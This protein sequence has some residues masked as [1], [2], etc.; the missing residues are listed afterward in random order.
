MKRRFTATAAALLIILTRC[1]SLSADDLSGAGHEYDNI[2]VAEAVESA[3]G[4]QAPA[5]S[6]AREGSLKLYAGFL[7]TLGVMRGFDDGTFRP[8]AP[9]LKGDACVITAAAAG[10]DTAAFADAPIG[11]FYDVDR[12]SPYFSAVQALAAYGILKGN[13]D[14]T[15]NVNTRLTYTEAVV[16]LTRVMG[17]EEFARVS[18]GYP[19][20]YFAAA[21]RAGVSFRSADGMTRGVFAEFIYNM[22]RSHPLQ[23]NRAGERNTY[24][25]NTEETFLSERHEVYEGD[26]IVTATRAGGLSGGAV[27]RGTV[28][29]DEDV[30]ALDQKA[31]AARLGYRTQFFYRDDDGAYTVIY[32][33][34]HRKVAEIEIDAEDY[35]NYTPSA[36][37][38]RYTEDD[39]R[40]VLT[41]VLSDAPTVLINGTA[42]AVPSLGAALEIQQGSITLVS[43]YDDDIY[44]LVCVN[45]YENL[46]LQRASADGGHTITLTPQYSLLPITARMSGDT[47]L[48]FANA[49]G[50]EVEYYADVP[51]VFGKDGKPAKTIDVSRIPADCVLSAFADKYEEQRGHLLPAGDA[52]YTRFVI[53]TRKIEGTI[54]AI[55]G[56]GNV[57]IGGKTFKSSPSNY[58]NELDGALTLGKTGLFYLDFSGEIVAFKESGA[59]DALRYGYLIN[60]GS[61]RGALS[62]TLQLKIMTDDGEI[63]VVTTERKTNVNGDSLS[64]DEALTLLKRVAGMLRGGFGI[65][66]MIR[67]RLTAD[68]ML[69]ELET[70]LPEDLIN[71]NGLVESAHLQRSVPID[72][73]NLVEDTSGRL[74]RAADDT[75]Y[76]KPNKYFF[77]PSP[78][79]FH[80]E[81]YSVQA[82]ANARPYSIELYDCGF[83]MRPQIA[84]IYA[85]AGGAEQEIITTR[86]AFPVMVS[87]V[88]K[89][90][91]KDGAAVGAVEVATGVVM[92]EY[93]GRDEHTFDGL[94]AGDLIQLYTRGND[95][96]SSYRR[97][98]YY[99][100]PITAKTFPDLDFDALTDGGSIR[101]L[102]AGVVYYV[103]SQSGLVIDTGRYGADG[104]RKIHVTG[105][106]N[107]NYYW[108]MGGAIVYDATV[109]AKPQ[110]RN[111]TISDFKGMYQYGEQH[112]S[113][114]LWI[115]A[116]GGGRQY[117][118]Y[119]F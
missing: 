82:P 26:G 81:D 5:F 80:D 102:Y 98:T 9:V 41:A 101:S 55:D 117:I 58:F 64:K 1:V 6:D 7:D 71:Q 66:Q 84:L 68:G 96:V 42:A 100:I 52:V 11:T 97:H 3:P 37:T 56:E 90:L 75:G 8:D 19:E 21:R 114:V 23:K 27:K 119:N 78:E 24:A 108:Q 91:D 36:K 112:A 18:G 109:G 4:E 12:D 105:H 46:L 72:E 47:I 62:D 99:N 34:D 16:L 49:D 43:N 13:A 73:Y 14:N 104:R 10:I 93:I 25:V 111:A 63:I 115:P 61:A 32:L 57:E 38:I 85:D 77:V 45:R 67:Y 29:I 69:A 54:E 79:T 20:G 28:K 83:D 74:L 22:L 35:V 107:T 33:I 30:Y 76:H 60:A 59:T 70:C 95:V 94:E 31:G 106:M 15:V 92:K 44:D 113:R 39:G 110:V 116:H 40:R 48:E 50:T 88:F 2:D 87:R 103:D 65:S 17:Y 53:S 89:K 86:F 118:L 51:G